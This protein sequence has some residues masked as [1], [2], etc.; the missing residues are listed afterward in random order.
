L[1]VLIPAKVDL[2][3]SSQEGGKPKIKIKKIKMQQQ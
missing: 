1:R 2:R 3:G